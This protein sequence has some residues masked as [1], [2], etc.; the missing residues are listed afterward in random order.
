[1]TNQISTV[2]FHG[3]P[4]SVIPHNNQLYVAIKPICE[5]MGIQWHAQRK[6]IQR[7]EVLSSVESIMDSTAADGK[8]YKYTC[9]PL[10]FINGWLFGVD[11]N[12][13]KPEIRENILQYKREC[14]KVLSDYWQKGFSVNPRSP[15][16]PDSFQQLSCLIEGKVK[17]LPD[18]SRRS[19]IARIWRQLHRAF[20]VKS[21]HDL[22]EDQ[23]PEARNFIAAYAVKGEWLPRQ[24]SL[25]PDSCSS[26]SLPRHK[27]W[28]EYR[29]DELC[30][31]DT[32][33]TATSHLIRTLLQAKKSQEPLQVKEISAVVEEVK[34]MRHLLELSQRPP[35]SLSKVPRSYLQ[36]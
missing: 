13:V 27:G 23:L 26:I 3:Q 25:L 34:A 17:S 8:N 33:L 31:P 35:K 2:D 29:A 1:M 24:E 12:R 15:I 19:A 21:G 14:F 18:K 6:R 22:T 28:H 10:E 32:Y 30:G 9:L 20:D 7:D 16:S 36:G 5:N 4:I 11:T